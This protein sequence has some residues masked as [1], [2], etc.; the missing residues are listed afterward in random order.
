MN[1]DLGEMQSL[2]ELRERVKWIVARRAVDHI[3]SMTLQIKNPW[4]HSYKLTIEFNVATAGRAWRDLNARD[5]LW[6][7]LGRNWENLLG[8]FCV[9]M[10][11]GWATAW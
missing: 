8:A 3:E 7:E 6:L 9:G 1:I 2:E 4:E 11:L 10:L 5:V